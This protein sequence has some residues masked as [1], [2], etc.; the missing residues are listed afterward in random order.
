MHRYLH[1][2]HQGSVVAFADAAGTVLGVNRYDPYGVPSA[3]NLGRYGYTGQAR[4]DELGRYYCAG[5]RGSTRCGRTFD[6]KKRCESGRNK[7]D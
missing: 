4:I 3:E 6:G 7:D 5:P 2:D 1:T